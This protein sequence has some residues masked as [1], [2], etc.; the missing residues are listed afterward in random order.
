LSC[1][2]SERGDSPFGA[3]IAA[4]KIAMRSHVSEPSRDEQ[5]PHGR[6]LFVAV[7]DRQ[8]AS[9]AEVPRRTSDDHA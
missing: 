3:A 6:A 4:R 1:R 9:A 5:L 2:G 8:P 7:L